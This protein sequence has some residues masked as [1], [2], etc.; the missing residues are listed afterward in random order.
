MVGRLAPL[1]ISLACAG[2]HAVSC[3]TITD[4]AAQ[5][6]TAQTAPADGY[7]P[8]APLFSPEDAGDDVRRM[9]E[10]A[11]HV[12]LPE[13][14]PPSAEEEA[15]D[16][17]LRMAN[18]LML[19]TSG[20]DPA[21]LGLDREGIEI[22]YTGAVSL[23]APDTY[24]LDDLVDGEDEGVPLDRLAL[25]RQYSDGANWYTGVSGE[26]GNE[27]E[28]RVPARLSH[29]IGDYGLRNGLMS[30][31]P[32]DK[33][34]DEGEAGRD[35]YGLDHGWLLDLIVPPAHAGL[36]G[37]DD[38]ELKGATDTAQTSNNLRRIVSFVPAGAADDANS[39]CTG[40]L[41]SRHHVLTAAHCLY[42]KRKPADTSTGA[43]AVVPGWNEWEH[44]VG[45]NGNDWHGEADST[46][47]W[48][49]YW[50]SSPYIAAARKSPSG[51][52]PKEFD[53]G[54]VVFPDRHIGTTWFGFWYSQQEND[55]MLNRGYPSC[56]VRAGKAPPP[57]NCDEGHMY[58]DTAACG[59]QGFTGGEDNAGYSRLGYHSCDTSGGQ[60]G[61][62]LYRFQD[63][64]HGYVLRGAHKG[65]P[66][67]DGW[68]SFALITKQRAEM[69]AY[70]KLIYP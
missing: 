60:S 18:G 49:W 11:V 15:N 45:R 23:A 9:A 26:T 28:V 38:R 68:Q 62:P 48:R 2:P 46:S 63:A 52:S 69:A 70:L 50:V 42:R 4:Q 33:T 40:A 36:V 59:T 24:D 55:D 30:S 54:I 65:I 39:V 17:R 67:P 29:L 53:I 27:F 66:G 5:D 7:G 21:D 25:P 22:R 43:A 10:L 41:F 56:V 31:S 12:F 47:G 1:M 14:F 35:P 51:G 20:I 58:G 19:A 37:S 6:R 34:P 61:S 44:R 3:Q 32:L 64:E 8:D 57:P 13:T 16:L